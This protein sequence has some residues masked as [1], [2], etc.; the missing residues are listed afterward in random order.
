[1]TTGMT[2]EV[3]VEFASTYSHIAAQRIEKEAE[4][5]G[6]SIVWR[7]FLLGPI[8][9]LQGLNDSPFNVNKL[10]GVY[11]WRDME[12]QCKS[13]NI[14]F[15]KPSVF[16]RNSLTAAR[17]ATAAEGESW[18]SAFIR[19]AFL[20]NF[21]LDQ[22][23]ADPQVLTEA[24]KRAECPDI[25][26]AIGSAQDQAT[27][28]KLRETN[29]EAISRGIFG[30]PNFIVGDELFWGNDRLEQAIAFAADEK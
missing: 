3:W 9:Q 1:M 16:P 25:E 4:K 12:R 26:K 11:M 20:A 24:L 2:I 10:K 30:A 13:F 7:P 6:I 29:D 14:P 21:Y 5:A 17:I 15:R 18:Q 23:I 8:F 19:E 27:K 28:N 22:D